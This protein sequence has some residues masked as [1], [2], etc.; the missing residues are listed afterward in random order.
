M[1]GGIRS[2][3]DISLLLKSG[4]DKISINTK[5]LQTPQFIKEAALK[6][7]SQCIVVSVDVKY[8]STSDQYE[9]YSEFGQKT[10]RRN[11]VE[12][13]KEAES[14]GAGEILLNSIDRD[15]TGKGYDL[16]LIKEV[17][18][19]VSIPVIALGGVGAFEHFVEGLVKGGAD[20]VAAA[21]IFQFT[22]QSIINAKKHMDSVGINVRM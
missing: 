6:F 2:V 21:N 9:V 22:E 18:S 19:N 1:G 8:D 14:L 4:A 20:A 10:T 16:R 7:G 15:G 11:P 13:C 3:E 17:S 12:W 5:A